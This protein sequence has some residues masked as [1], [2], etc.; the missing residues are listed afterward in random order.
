MRRP[1]AGPEGELLPQLL[2]EVPGPLSQALVD[3]L[4]ASECPAVT[5]RRARRAR[6]EGVSQDP[7]VWERARGANVW[8]VDGNRF[9]DL[10]SAFGV[11]TLGHSRPEV[12]EA[13]Q[14]QLSLLPHGMGDVFPNRVKIELAR[15]LV[16]VAPHGI[17][18]VLY[19]CTGSEAI[20]AAWKTCVLATGK[21]EIIAF[22]GSYHGLSLGALSVSAYRR[23]FRE[24]FLPLLSSRVHRVPYPDAR[25]PPRGVA[26]KDM[27]EFVLGAIESLVT[28]PDSGGTAIGAVF[29]EPILGRGGVVVPPPGFLASLAEL[30]R[31]LGILLVLDEILTGFGRTGEWFAAGYE[32]V[33]PDLLCVGKGLTGGY[34]LSACLGKAEVMD[35][36]GTSTGEALHTSTFQGNPVGAAMALASLKVLANGGLQQCRQTGEALGEALVALQRRHP[37][38]LVDVR[39]RGLMWGVEW[40]DRKGGGRAPSPPAAVS[41]SRFLQERG[42]LCMPAGASGRVLAIE[43]PS[44]L[45]A[46]QLEGFIAALDEFLVA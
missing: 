33:V 6:E 7:L 23:E 43:P 11:T 38:V 30:C 22:S 29:I 1:E 41:A 20:D 10:T 27:G 12:V 28:S 21:P 19:T 3:D 18:R 34:P 42:Y 15:R 40:A 2:T 31:R 17:N 37:Q 5:A 9:V 36:W 24:P 32:G 46:S 25:N 45:T 13:A 44:C 16:E 4:A 8:D 14:A 35:R 26:G 39:G